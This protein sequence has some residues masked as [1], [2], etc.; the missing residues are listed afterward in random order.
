MAKD[1]LEYK[2]QFK[3]HCILKLVAYGAGVLALLFVLFLP[4]FEWTD[5]LLIELVTLFE[6]DASFSLFDEAKLMIE[7]MK[8]E[9][10]KHFIIEYALHGATD[11]EEALQSFSSFMGIFYLLGILLMA[12]GIVMVAVEGVK[13]YQCLTDLEGYTA[14]Q[15]DKIKWRQEEKK[16]WKKQSSPMNLMSGAIS[17]FFGYIFFAW[18]MASAFEGMGME[19]TVSYFTFADFALTGWIWL[20]II[21]VVVM[22]ILHLKA[23]GVYKKIQRSVIKDEYEEKK[24][25]NEN[26]FKEE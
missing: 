2:G 21:C 22:E 17:C 10:G 1:Y 12:T 26:I 16:S 18:I 9:E 7:L 11:E 5:E 13:A 24:K 8:G 25:A 15:Y 20:V 3:K 4:L 23:K 14:E 6:K 19:G